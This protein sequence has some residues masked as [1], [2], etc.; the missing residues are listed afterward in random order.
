MQR[1]PRRPAKRTLDGEDRSGIIRNEGKGDLS[2]F[3]VSSSLTQ[4]YAEQSIF[5]LTVVTG[6]SAYALYAVLR[7]DAP[8]EQAS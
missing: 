5:A 3:P 1:P 7:T 4:W 2:H 8:R 6:L